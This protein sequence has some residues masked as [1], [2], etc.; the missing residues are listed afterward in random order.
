MPL[1]RN[2]RKPARLTPTAPKVAV[3]PR[4]ATL[5]IPRMVGEGSLVRRVNRDP[6]IRQ[7]LV[8][9]FEDCPRKGILQWAYALRPYHRASALDKGNY[10]HVACRMAVEGKSIKAVEAWCQ[11]TYQEVVR[12]IASKPEYRDNPDNVPVGVL[13]DRTKD[14]NI[15]L[16]TGLR[17]ARLLT[18]QID[19]GLLR[20]LGFEVPLAGRLNI[21]GL[22]FDFAGQVDMPF[23]DNNDYYY[24]FDLKTT[25][26]MPTI[27]ASYFWSK[28]Q[29]PLYVAA[30]RQ[31]LAGDVVPDTTR[32]GGFLPL[33]IQKPTIRQKK[34]RGSTPPQSL[35]DYLLECEEAWDGTGR[36]EGKRLDRQSS[37]PFV[38]HPPIAGGPTPLSVRTRVERVLDYMS[39]PLE[40]DNFP[41]CERHCQD[42]AYSR[43]CYDTTGR[44]WRDT[45]NQHFTQAPDPLDSDPTRVPLPVLQTTKKGL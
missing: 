13:D 31:G 14:M 39:R 4:P 23:A 17:A 30:M 40:L 42:C 32:V 33:I 27:F 26:L 1:I 15:G 35:E 11:N 10:A 9:A 41:H 43:I 18:E 16:A 3:T 12:D 19:K 21:H 38:L 25:D 36:H 8:T 34:G 45:I 2:R 29:P 7:S 5:D 37:P 6:V 24:P 28:I 44:N 22:E 20:P